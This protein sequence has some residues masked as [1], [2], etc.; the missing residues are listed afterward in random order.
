MPK[1]N[2]LKYNLNL[3]LAITLLILSIFLTLIVYS[4]SKKKLN[5]KPNILIK[6]FLTI[7]IS[8]ILLLS[9]ASG[10]FDY[11]WGNLYRVTGVALFFMGIVFWVLVV[12]LSKNNNKLKYISLFLILVISQVKFLYAVR[13]EHYNKNVRFLYGNHNQISD[14]II[15]YLIS[16]ENK[17]KKINIFTGGE[18]QGRNLFGLLSY[19]K[20]LRVD[21]FYDIFEHK[22]KIPIDNLLISK[23]DYNLYFKN[24]EMSYHAEEMIDNQ[25]IYLTKSLI[26]LEK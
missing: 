25:L 10:I 5:S 8:Y 17:I 26:K 22:D 9:T 4:V 20:I 15:N 11:K 3:S 19:N 16:D 23:T 24:I 2:Y 6:F 14:N 21:K 12:A 13:Y 1:V 18:W 7:A